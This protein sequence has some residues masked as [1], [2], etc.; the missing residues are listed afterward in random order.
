[1]RVIVSVAVAL[2]ALAYAV[3]QR[4][5]VLGVFTWALQSEAGVWI[6]DALRKLFGESQIAQVCAPFTFAQFT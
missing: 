2:A 6:V 5:W 1:M 3:V 4:E